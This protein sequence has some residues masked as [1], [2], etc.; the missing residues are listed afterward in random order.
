MSELF[1]TASEQST[2]PAGRSRLSRGLPD[3]DAN[4]AAAP[5]GLSPRLWRRAR[6]PA[7]LFL[8]TCFSTFWVGVTNWQ[9]TQAIT[10]CVAQDDWTYVRQLI[11]V[12]W[13]QGLLYMGCVLAILVL[14]ELGHFVMTLVYRIPATMPIFLPFPF[15][16]IGTLGAVIGMNG[17]EANRRQIFDIGIA[18]PLAGLVVAVPLAWLGVRD[19]DLTQ[20][21][22]AGGLQFQS[23]LFLDWLLEWAAVPGYNGS[24]ISP[25][26]VNPFLAAA[27]V[28]FLVTGLNMIPVGQLDGGHITYALF[29]QFA[30]QLARWIIIGAIA[31]MV[32]S[33]HMVLLLMVVL[34]IL[35]GTDH[36]P[37]ADDT[38]R[39][40]WFRWV[41]GL[42]SLSIPILFFPPRVFDL[43]I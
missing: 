3:A 42:L 11:G 23:P 34:V 28:G 5:S 24:S 29:G 10:I 13:P 36:P 9:P 2:Q 40:G 43:P 32:Y 17:L 12:H 22:P 21:V 25:S 4:E 31:A 19:L 41:L 6:W 20:A 26:Q 15:N 14:H 8:L 18:G 33:G 7:L 39:L 16:P 38:V 37:T 1:E 27:W 30:H 35:V